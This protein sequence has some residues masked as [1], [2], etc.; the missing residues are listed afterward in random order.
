MIAAP[1]SQLYV[2]NAGASDDKDDDSLWARIRKPAVSSSTFA[3]SVKA[4]TAGKHGTSNGAGK[5][6]SG[7]DWVDFE[8]SDEEDGEAGFGAR[9][10]TR[11]EGDGEDVPFA[12]ALEDEEA[13]GKG[14]AAGRK[15]HELLKGGSSSGSGD[16]AS[17]DDED[18]GRGRGRGERR[19]GE[20]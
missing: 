3:K 14:K 17:S 11:E 19:G 2:T 4:A 16:E 9:D 20:V 15:V 13:A 1:L 10:V 18:V 5:R 7:G 12:M 8:G 6:T